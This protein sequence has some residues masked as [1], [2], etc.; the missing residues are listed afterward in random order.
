LLLLVLQ[1]LLLLRADC[2]RRLELLLLLM[3]LLSPV[4]GHK[5][6][7]QHHRQQTVSAGVGVGALQYQLTHDS[8]VV[9]QIEVLTSRSCTDSPHSWPPHPSRC[10][11]AQG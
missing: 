5:K 9:L 7:N 3:L 4:P 6:F 1:L 2:W 8:F 11:S 10:L